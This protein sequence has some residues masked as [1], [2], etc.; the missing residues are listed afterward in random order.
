MQS[1][2]SGPNALKN[3]DLSQPSVARVYDYYLGGSSNWAVD[4]EFA[5][6]VLEAFPL[7]RDIAVANRS[8]HHRVVHDLA[9]R[10]IRQFL[11]V[12]AGIPREGSTHRMADEVVPDCRVVYVDN[13]PVAVAHAEILVDEEG[14]PDRHAVVN[15]D[16][17]EPDRLWRD[18]YATGIID[19]EQPVALL[20]IAV[21]HVHQPGK[22]GSDIWEQSVARYR[23]LLPQGSYLALSHLTGDGVPPEIK[24]KLGQL[25]KMYD[26]SGNKVIC[27]RRDQICA[28]L[29]NFE[30]L[31]PG[32]VWA[33]EWR[34]WGTPT[35]DG[36]ATSNASAIWA[37]VARKQ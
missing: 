31:D 1:L 5:D 33:P 24:A 35:R 15:G 30:P 20:M 10:G 23:E 25:K 12:G 2:T 26:D 16:L 14:D 3:V 29:G 37:G 19:P 21:L 34:P 27:R 8:F 18:V 36:F 9:R 32:M 7:F 6:R 17:R 11:D 22:D 13:E 4:R 28:L